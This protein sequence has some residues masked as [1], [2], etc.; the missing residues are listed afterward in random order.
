LAPPV[1][2][3]NVLDV[4]QDVEPLV[5]AIRLIRKIFGAPAFK[6]Y[7]VR[8]IAPGESVQSDAD[9]IAYIRAEGYTVHHPVSTCRMG[10][11]AMAV[12]DSQ[13]RVAGLEGLRV[14]DASVFPSIIGGN[15]NAVVVMVA[16][17]AADMLL[18]RPPLA[19]AS[20]TS[21]QEPL[22]CQKS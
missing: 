10:N 14:A 16:E 1:I 8:E 17:K 5:R 3:P 18:G 6:K 2:D 11:D 13:L 15:T 7:G 9:L 22:S 4:P 20:S 12:V 19:R 21:C